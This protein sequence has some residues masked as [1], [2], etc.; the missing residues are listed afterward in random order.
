LVVL[1][2]LHRHSSC[3]CVTS[4]VRDIRTMLD[5]T[6]LHAKH[7]ILCKFIRCQLKSKGKRVLN[8]LTPSAYSPRPPGAHILCNLKMERLEG[9]KVTWL[10]FTEPALEIS[11]AK[12]MIVRSLTS[13]H[14]PCNSNFG[15][16]TTSTYYSSPRWT[17]S[18]FSD[19]FLKQ[20]STVTPS[21]RAVFS[22]VLGSRAIP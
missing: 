6:Q 2:Y 3:K 11:K 20:R 18:V 10:Q 13:Y 1:T 5:D 16:D 8:A 21:T 14:A 9:R 4:I 12:R 19:Y 17:S 15:V 7:Y 22:L